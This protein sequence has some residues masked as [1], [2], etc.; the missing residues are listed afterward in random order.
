ML[1]SRAQW[2]P[3]LAALAQVCTPVTVEL[4][5]HGRSASPTDPEAYTVQAY[6]NRFEALREHL[7]LEQWFICGQSFGA[8]LTIRYSLM[9]P[10]RIIGQVFTNSMSGLS[11][12]GRA[13]SPE[14]LARADAV[15]QG[16]REALKAIPFHPRPAR[17][18]PPEIWEDLVAD[19]DLLS[20]SA[21]AQ[22]L[23]ITSP[24]LSVETDLTR[25]S[26]PTLLVNGKRETAFQPL[27]DLAAREIP[28]LTVVDLEGGHSVNLDQAAGFNAAVTAFI[29]RCG[30]G[31]GA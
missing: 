17:R 8:G 28:G 5:G 9:H 14:R 10:E 27:R 4:L 31:N 11:S 18:L 12:V 22:T 13:R 15:E 26:V 6:V 16:G 7:G 30:P 25:V 2:R 1:S 29:Q 20:P 19:A 23:R 24:D 21:V 3:N